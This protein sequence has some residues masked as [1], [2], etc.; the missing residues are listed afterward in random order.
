MDQKLSSCKILLQATR[1]ACS[2]NLQAAIVHGQHIGSRQLFLLPL[3]MNG[4]QEGNLIAHLEFCHSKSYHKCFE[5]IV[6][7]LQ[8]WSKS[9]WLLLD[10]ARTPF[11]LGLLILKKESDCLQE[12]RKR[13]TWEQNLK[14]GHSPPENTRPIKI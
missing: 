9:I 1:G 7:I 4:M 10:L 2:P 12:N 14:A 3:R 11:N 6:S 5:N 8:H 13:L